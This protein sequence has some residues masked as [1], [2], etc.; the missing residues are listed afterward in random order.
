MSGNQVILLLAG[1]QFQFARHGQSQQWVSELLPHTARI[2][3]T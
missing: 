2:V 1:A 3:T